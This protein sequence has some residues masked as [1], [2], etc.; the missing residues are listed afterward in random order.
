MSTVLL[1]AIASANL[2]ALGRFLT[3]RTASQ[4]STRRQKCEYDE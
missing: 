1:V 2:D 3:R 4:D